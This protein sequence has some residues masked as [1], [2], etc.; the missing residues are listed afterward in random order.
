MEE[1][2]KE[3]GQKAGK[4]LSKVPIIIADISRKHSLNEMALKAR[5]IVNCVGPYRFYG[6]PVV[7]AC[8]EN[9]THH[10]DV[11]GEPQFMERMQL[12][13][14]E[15]AKNQGVYIISACGYDSIPVEMGTIFLEDNFKGCVNS[16]ETYMYLKM[17]KRPP[18]F[19]SLI[20]YATWESALYVLSYNDELLRIRKRLFLKDLPKTEPELKNRGLIHR[21]KFLYNLICL[22]FHGS[23]KSVVMRSQRHFYENENKRPIQMKEYMAFDSIIYLMS[24]LYIG[25][26]F[27]VLSKFSLGRKLLRKY[28]R[29]FSMGGVSH[30]GPSEETMKNSKFEIILHGQG[31]KEKLESPT[32]K[33]TIP[34]NKKMVVKVTGT[35]PG[36]GAT[37]VA[38]LIA[39]KTIL[40]EASKMPG[41]G[42]VLSPGAAFKNINLIEN[43]QDHGIKFEVLEVKE[44]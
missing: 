18:L 9:G 30:E 27:L 32:D 10:V 21:S 22:P 23:D 44:N 7:R 33:Y 38:L 2:L 24:F 41:N 36:Y 3:I 19:S 42:G 29:L 40:L 37:C 20:H 34:M 26:I 15:A 1:T 39:A 17:L 16:V 6:E 35:N 8:I 31:W 4:D 5:V 28:P 14:N 25:A 43:L 12:E 13:Y 11:S